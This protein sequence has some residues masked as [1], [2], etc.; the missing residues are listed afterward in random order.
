MDTQHALEIVSYKLGLKIGEEALKDPVLLPEVIKQAIKDKEDSDQK[1]ITLREYMTAT[2]VVQTVRLEHQREDGVKWLEE[3][4]KEEGIVTTDSGLRYKVL[5][6]GGG[7]KCWPG[8]T[9]KVHYEGKLQD[10]TPFDS[11]YDR[12]EPASFPVKAVIKGWQEGLE[13]MTVGSRYQF[14][15]PQELGYGER[16]AGSD[17]PPYAALFFEVELLAAF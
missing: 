3:L 2:K 13:L 15:I 6:K 16:G 5:E 7:Q 17:I 4:S 12:G 10:G 14:F 1:S 8:A 9:A 11:S